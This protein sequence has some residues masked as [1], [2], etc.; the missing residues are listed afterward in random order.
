MLGLDVSLKLTRD[1]SD[2]HKGPPWLLWVEMCISGVSLWQALN[3][4]TAT[5]Q[6]LPLEGCHS[7]SG[8]PLAICL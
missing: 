3:P 8:T 1:M 7:G 4:A 2:I 5:I 6:D